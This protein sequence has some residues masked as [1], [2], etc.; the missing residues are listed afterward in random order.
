MH[1]RGSRGVSSGSL[2]GEADQVQ[3][4][5]QAWGADRRTKAPSH[6]DGR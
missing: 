2:R 1:A 4:S 5:S 3:L 6:V